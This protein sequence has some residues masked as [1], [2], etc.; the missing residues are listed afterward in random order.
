MLT[1]KINNHQDKTQR[2]VG[3]GYSKIQTV[4]SLKDLNSQYKNDSQTVL[5]EKSRKV[6]EKAETS[7]TLASSKSMSKISPS[8]SFFRVERE[9]TSST[10]TLNYNL[11]SPNLD[12]NRE[13]REESVS[14]RQISIPDCQ[15]ETAKKKP[16]FTRSRNA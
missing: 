10:T 14:R 4:K 16:K 2:R 1:R 8:T 6:E 13:Y 7:M 9:M 11:S 15:N 3:F 5:E 12:K